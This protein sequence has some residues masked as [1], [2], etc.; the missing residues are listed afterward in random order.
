[1]RIISNRK[2]FTLIELLVVIAIIAILAA[3]L[4]PVFAKAREKARQASC[5]SNMRQLGLG[6]AQYTND[7]DE[8]E[9]AIYNWGSEIYP[10]VKATG[11]YQCPDDSNT[12]NTSG[13]GT[14]YPLSYAINQN[15]AGQNIAG[16]SSPSVTVLLSEDDS[17]SV[18][19]TSSTD[20]NI[21]SN[22]NGVNPND[23]VA[24]GNLKALGTGTT[25]SP[26]QHDP[27]LMFL[28]ADGHVKLLRPEHVS[29]GANAGASTSTQVAGSYAAGSDALSTTW[30]LTFSEL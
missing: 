17:A 23:V 16:I 24:W 9:P 29:G 14:T 26:T 21:Y 27:S 22:T 3:I 8:L 30:T 2:G 12:V 15:L 5:Q 13:N 25:S 10:Y 28:G 20:T 19:M 18:N 1:M 11:V 6:F 7:Y 4:F